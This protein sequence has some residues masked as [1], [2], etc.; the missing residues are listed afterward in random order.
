MARLRA[1]RA[2]SR[3]KAIATR[4]SKVEEGRAS[5]AC[6]PADC[7]EL[8]AC[9]LDTSSALA[10]LRTCRTVHSNLLPCT[11]FWKHLVYNEGFDNYSC[12]K[13][14]DG[15]DER[16]T[17]C[18]SSLHSLEM[19]AEATHWQKVFQRGLG[20]RRNLTSAKF[21]M[22]RLFMTGEEHLP[23]KQMT[24]DTTFRELRS[25]HRGSPFLDRQRR[26]RVNRYWNEEFLVVLQHN[27]QHEFNTLFVWAWKEC[28][29]PK[30][31]YSRNLMDL[32]PTGLFP[33]AFFLYKNFLVLMPDTAGISTSNTFTSL[34]RVH[35]LTADFALAGSYSLPEDE[36][37]RRIKVTQGCAEAAHLHR[38]GDKAVALCRSP[39]LTLYIFSLPDC[40]LETVLPLQAQPGLPLLDNHDLDQRY[41]VKDNKMFFFFHDREFFS[42]LFAPE[43]TDQ[44]EEKFGSLLQIDFDNFLN[45]KG[46]VD[47]RIDCKFDTNLEYI[48]K[49]QLMKDGRMLVSLASGRILMKEVVAGKAGELGCHQV[50]SL[51]CPEPLQEEFDEASE[52][53]VETDGPTV[54]CSRSGD[55]IIA[56]RHF[57]SGRR[58]HAYNGTGDLLYTFSLD[59]PE[60]GL[61]PR[62]G[63]LSLDMDGR[64]L[65][66]AD[67]GR[68]VVWDS[69]TGRHLRTI[70]L[71]PHYSRRA[72]PSE[73]EDR[74]C[75]KG[76]TDFAFT[77][78]GI[79]IIHSQR[80]APVAADI[81]LFW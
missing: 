80:N 72:D 14:E 51:P 59:A 66:A 64:F 63:Y 67:Q 71:P 21:E 65:C 55:I 10:L 32:Y 17:W 48:E 79:I 12:L 62:P 54:T 56:M 3:R 49:I 20:M 24:M 41:L 30:F 74:F 2:A 77:E 29:E 7:L 11:H 25:A 23:T 70:V 15:E 34:I 61:E 33:T 4:P 81:F 75:W 50:L 47:M 38:M 27:A 18:G 43:D 8:I 37:A 35:D 6:L 53:E 42:H 69:K 44:V 26:V 19:P 9:L 46:K 22:W 57:A 73:D 58:V 39:T 40:T 5:L 1:L 76:H 60:F 45:K 78:D 16:R 36:A 52:E 68:V 13:K 31:L 28:K